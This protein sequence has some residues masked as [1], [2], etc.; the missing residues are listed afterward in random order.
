MRSRTRQN[1][2]CGRAIESAAFDDSIDE[3]CRQSLTR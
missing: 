1:H 2:L 3:P